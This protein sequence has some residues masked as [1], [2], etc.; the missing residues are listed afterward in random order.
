MEDENGDQHWNATKWRSWLAVKNANLF[1]VGGSQ[2]H[3][4]YLNIAIFYIN[5]LKTLRYPGLW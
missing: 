4:K 3:H 2:R 5:S 1:G